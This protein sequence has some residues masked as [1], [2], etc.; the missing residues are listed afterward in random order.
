MAF[1]GKRSHV[2][3]LGDHTSTNTTHTSPQRKR[4][5][6]DVHR[7]T[8]EYSSPAN[9]DDDGHDTGY[10]SIDSIVHPSRKVQLNFPD[11]NALAQLVNRSAEED[12]PLNNGNTVNNISAGS[13]N[14]DSCSASGANYLATSMPRPVSRH[15]SCFVPQSDLIARE[16][17]F[18]YIVQ[19]IDEV[20]ARY[21]DTTSSAENQLYPYGYASPISDGENS[22]HESDSGY[23]SATEVETDC[24]SRKVSNLP[25]SVELQSL[26]DRLTKAKHSLEL[27]VDSDQFNDCVVFW[28]RWDMIKYNAVEM[29]EEDDDDELVESVIDELEQGRW[30]NEC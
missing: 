2:L 23:K 7:Y 6:L 20:W 27:T 21:C 3:L 13:S 25:D 28:N 9:S 10:S 12:L 22:G 19:S 17:C 30:Y 29:M 1:T 5:K 14:V 4:V 18:D 11:P 26:K 15:S 16:R 24:E 8:Q